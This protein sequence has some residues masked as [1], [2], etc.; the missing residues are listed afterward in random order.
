MIHKKYHGNT[1]YLLRNIDAG[2]QE[3]VETR[4][5][6]DGGQTTRTDELQMMTSH[7]GHT[8][9]SHKH[10]AQMDCTK[11]DD[12]MSNNGNDEQCFWMLQSNT[13]AYGGPV[14]GYSNRNMSKTKGWTLLGSLLK[15]WM[16]E[17]VSQQ[18]NK[19]Q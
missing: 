6:V 18:S 13:G 3:F 15:L 10:I 16:D 14:T 1:G 8:S 17:N 4:N 19:N 11:Q 9:Q 2:T 12:I 5:R 7:Q